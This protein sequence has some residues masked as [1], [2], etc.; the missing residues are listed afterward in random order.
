M[1]GQQN[2]NIYGQLGVTSQCIIT[3]DVSCR[4]HAECKAIH[5]PETLTYHKVPTFI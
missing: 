1:Q 3:N 2:I 4:T 5:F